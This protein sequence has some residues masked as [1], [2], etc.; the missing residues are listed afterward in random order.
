MEHLWGPRLN[1]RPGYRCERCCMVSITE[2]HQF[3]PCGG[4]EL[5]ACDHDKRFG[6]VFG[7]T[8]GCLACELESVAADWREL[9]AIVEPLNRL[10]ANE[11]ASVTINCPNP[12]G[13]PNEAIEVSDDWTGPEWEPKRFEGET[14]AECFRKA[15]HEK[16]NAEQIKANEREASQ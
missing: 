2:K 9:Q 10:R 6:G 15:E 1:G 12:E 14:L 8:R 4:E 7:A 16:R 13:P 3:A 11:G 5:A